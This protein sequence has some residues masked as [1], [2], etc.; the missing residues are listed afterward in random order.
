MPVVD[1]EM[2]NSV[3]PLIVVVTCSTKHHRKTLNFISWGL[4]TFN[5]SHVLVLLPFL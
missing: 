2:I 4:L 5:L 1:E 3:I